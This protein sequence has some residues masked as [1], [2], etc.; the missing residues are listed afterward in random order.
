[1][2]WEYSGTLTSLAKATTTDC[3][4]LCVSRGH[5]YS[6]PTLIKL[7]R[8]DT[9]RQL[10]FFFVFLP[11]VLSRL[12]LSYIVRISSLFAFCLYATPS[13]LHFYFFSGLFL[14]FSLRSCTFASCF[15]F[16]FSFLLR[17]FKY[18]M[19]NPYNH[20]LRISWHA[21]SLQPSSLFFFK[22]SNERTIISLRGQIVRHAF[23]LA[24]QRPCSVCHAVFFHN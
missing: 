14:S 15:L 13:A 12:S 10:L 11:E 7:F 18:A 8:R 21:W 22:Q 16:V 17:L 6:C 3:L 5:G 19:N 2:S 20:P 23:L 9:W 4:S 1:M 24:H